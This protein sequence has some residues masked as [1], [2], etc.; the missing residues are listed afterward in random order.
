MINLTSLI[1]TVRSLPEALGMDSPPLPQGTLGS[2]PMHAQG[3]QD[4]LVSGKEEDEGMFS[5]VFGTVTEIISSGS[6]GCM[7]NTGLD[8]LGLPDVIGDIAGGVLDFA[9]GNYVGAAANALDACEDLAKACGADD[10]AGYL[11]TGAEI[12]SM[13]SSPTGEIGAIVGKVAQGVDVLKTGA[14]TFEAASNGDITG[15]A[16][17]A[18]SMMG[19]LAGLSPEHADA[20]KNV[21]NVGTQVTTWVEQAGAD[22]EYSWS[23]LK[24]APLGALA[25][26]LGVDPKHAQTAQD[27]VQT[28]GGIAAGDGPEALISQFFDALMQHTS[29]EDLTRAA[30]ALSGF[31]ALKELILTAGSDDGAKAAI[32]LLQQGAQLQQTVDVQSHHRA[33]MR[34]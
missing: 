17:G 16:H 13:F 8:K 6:L 23:D 12:T 19:Q 25:T 14:E 9:T 1:N 31:D 27:I 33:N 7:L 22:G 18:F 32:E 3:P 2:G 10:I 30:E 4:E 24:D 26:T 28:I 11:K 5:K 21:A 29:S 15:M 34:V 20:L